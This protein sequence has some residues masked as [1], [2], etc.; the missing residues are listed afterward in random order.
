MVMVLILSALA[1][2]RSGWAA[3]PSTVFLPVRI[4]LDGFVREAEAWIPSDY[5]S[6][7]QVVEKTAFG[8]PLK[9]PVATRF[10]LR[11]RPIEWRTTGDRIQMRLP[12]SY[13][14]ELGRP[15]LERTSP[16]RLGMGWKTVTSCAPPAGAALRIETAL[17]LHSDWSVTARSRPTLELQAPCRLQAL[18]ETVS[19]DI[20]PQVRQ[21][22]QS[23]L[24]RAAVELD[25]QIAARADLRQIAKTLWGRLHEPI[26]LGEQ[27]WLKLQPQSVSLEMPRLEGGEIRTGLRLLGQPQLS[28]AKDSL[29]RPTP[30]P[31]LVPTPAGELPVFRMELDLDVPWAEVNQRLQEAMAGKEFKTAG[32]RRLRVVSASVAANGDRLVLDATVEGSFKGRVGMSGLPIIREGVLHFDDLRYTLATDSLLVRFANWLRQD[33]YRRQ[34]E[35]L[36]TVN[37]VDLLTRQRQRI[38]ESMRTNWTGE[39]RLDGQIDRVESATVALTPESVRL[40]A[41]ASGQV[42][43]VVAR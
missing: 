20:T 18:G 33:F 27:V 19:L 42:T 37:L 7:W 35:T 22:F 14:V 28:G 43:V 39:L 8:Q 6:E 41:T 38:E 3:E 13:R 10:S 36:A 29:T 26:A 5:Q 21:A 9:A 16:A 24:E 32:N 31:P 17:E 12:V 30:L 34:F 15:N 11:R 23:S 1:A 2:T 25:R 40:R 4:P